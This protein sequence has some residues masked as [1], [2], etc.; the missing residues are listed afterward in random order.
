MK[1]GEIEQARPYRVRICEL[2]HHNPPGFPYCRVCGGSLYQPVTVMNLHL[3]WVRASDGQMRPLTGDIVVGRAPEIRK[4]RDV[5]TLETPPEILEISR[6]H[7]R[8]HQN[9]WV[10]CVQDL[11]SENGTLLR[12]ANGEIWELNPQ[13]VYNVQPGDTVKLA[14]GYELKFEA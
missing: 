6:Q 13:R 3:G 14:P 4:M 1:Q 7:L 9:G 11:G 12:R 8:I 5:T 2:G 10:V